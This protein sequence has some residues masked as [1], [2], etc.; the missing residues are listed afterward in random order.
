MSEPTLT[1]I[2]YQLAQITNQISQTNNRFDRLEERI[3]K[4]EKRLEEEVKRWDERFFQFTRDNLGISRTISI[5]AGTV[6][7]LSPLL[8]A[9]APAIKAVVERFIGAGA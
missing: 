2:A 8:Q 3:E 5:T 6:V 1:D 7:V 9:F 4:S